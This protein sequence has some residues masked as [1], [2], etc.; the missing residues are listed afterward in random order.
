VTQTTLKMNSIIFYKHS[1]IIFFMDIF[2]HAKLPSFNVPVSPGICISKHNLY[3]INDNLY[4][5]PNNSFD[6]NDRIL[7][8]PDN[9]KSTSIYSLL[10][11]HE[12]NI[13]KIHPLFLLEFFFFFTFLFFILFC[14]KNKWIN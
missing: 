9:T 5:L 10:I 6:Q 11:V 7:I 1:F 12:K 14:D 8:L 3:I 13:C 2:N 4:S